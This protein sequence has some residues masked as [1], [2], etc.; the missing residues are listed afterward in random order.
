[1]KLTQEERLVLAGLTALAIEERKK[2]NNTE[3]AICGFLKRHGVDETEA[4]NWAGELVYSEGDDP[5]KAANSVLACLF[6]DALN[7]P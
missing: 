7:V 3:S 5:I 2:L 1:M 6:D 4:E